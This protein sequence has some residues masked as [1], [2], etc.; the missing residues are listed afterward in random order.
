LYSATSQVQFPSFFCFFLF[1]ICFTSSHLITHTH[2]NT[3]T[4]TPRSVGLP[5]TRN[6][7]VA[8]ISIWHTHKKQTAVSPEGFE[9]AIAKS[10]RM[11]TH[12][13]DCAAKSFNFSCISAGSWKNLVGIPV[14]LKAGRIQ[15]SSLQGKICCSPPDLPGRMWGELNLLLNGYR[16]W[17]CWGNAEKRR[18]D[19]GV[20]LRKYKV[21]FNC[22]IYLQTDNPEFRSSHTNNDTQGRPRPV[23]APDRLIIW[24]AFKLIS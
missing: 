12:T 2:T 7:P 23:E 13:W 6:R 18:G 15:V 9:P 20:W 24:P 22:E 5:W 3:H 16:S 19:N 8:E 14:R 10:E 17:F 11:Q 4:H 21:C 1:L